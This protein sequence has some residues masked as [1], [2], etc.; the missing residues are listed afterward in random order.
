M[1]SSIFRA[2][3]VRGIYGKDLT[4]KTMEIIGN[5]LARFLEEDRVVVARDPRLSGESLNKAFISGF[6]KTG[7]DV[8]DVGMVPLGTG[9]LYAWKRKIPFAYITGSHLTKEWNGIKFFHKNAVGFLEEDNN[10]VRDMSLEERLLEKGRGNVERIDTNRV[11]DEYVDFMIS[12]IKPERSLKIVL[13]CGNGAAGAVARKL[14][15]K[16]GFEADMVFEEPDGNF[17][18]RSPDNFEDP[19]RE[20]KKRVKEADFG[21]AYDGDGDRIVIIDSD[22]NTLTPEQTSYIILSELLEK[23]GG[24]VVA[25]VECT[26]AIDLIAEKFGREVKRI[27]VGHTFLMS[28]VQK[29]RAS[30]GVESAG[31]YVIPSIFPADDSLA[32]SYYFACVLSEKT[33]RLSDI[34]REIP[35]YPFKRVNF[36]C[37]DDKKFLVVE[38]IKERMKSEYKDINTLDGVRIDLEDGW[39]LIRASNTSPMIRLTIEGE[40][41]EAFRDIKAKFSGIVKEAIDSVKQ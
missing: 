6:T 29:F 16:A 5:S 3:D 27:R 24:P 2:Y 17:P 33:E 37:D 9:V 8:I 23:E 35:T 30:F 26:K 4:D 34:M 14:F 21:I 40:N 20:A 22:G 19:L 13:D 7:K 38:K 11:L 25:N 12:K 41:E 31:H 28:S 36:D 15:E 39:A 1:Q 32:V 10:R 18:N